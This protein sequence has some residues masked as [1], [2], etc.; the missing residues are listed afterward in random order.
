MFCRMDLRVRRARARA[1]RE[2]SG[3]RTENQNADCARDGGGRPRV[4]VLLRGWAFVVC[5]CALSVCVYLWILLPVSVLSTCGPAS[6]RESGERR[7]RE[8]RTKPMTEDTRT[9]G[10]IAPIVGFSFPFFLFLVLFNSVSS[11][12]PRKQT[13]TTTTRQRTDSCADPSTSTFPSIHPHAPSTHARTRAG[14]GRR[15]RKT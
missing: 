8:E 12:E 7:E 13:D 5:V 14:G 15:T 10:I 6:E 1:R 2:E 3:E 9:D 11:I 4:W